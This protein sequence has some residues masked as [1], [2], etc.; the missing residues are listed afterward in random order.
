MWM[1]L[2]QNLTRMRAFAIYGVMLILV[3]IYINT[4]VDLVA[5]ARFW[6]DE[7]LAIVAA[8]Q[9]SFSAVWDAIWNGAEFSPPAYHFLLHLAPHLGGVGDFVLLRLPS[10]LALLFSALCIY[11]LLQSRLSKPLALLGFGVALNSGL[12]VFA[13]QARQYALVALCLSLALLLWDDRDRG[14]ISRPRAFLLWLT[15]VA[16]ICLHVY[17]LMAGVVIGLCEAMWF[18]R[19]RRIR[20]AIW[21]ALLGTLP[22]V[23]LL[24]R[25]LL[26]LASFN[27]HD[28]SSGA[29]YAKPT[30]ERF[31]DAVV[32]LLIGN[33][34]IKLIV[35]AA[36]IGVACGA[37]FFARIETGLGQ[38]LERVWPQEP[39]QASP[40][41][42]NIILLAMLLMPLVAQAFS[43]VVTG[44]FSPRYISAFA[45]FPALAIPAAIARLRF[46]RLLALALIPV[47]IGAFWLQN[48]RGVGAEK[49][50]F[51]LDMLRGVET[52]KPI[53]IAEGL[54]YIELAVAADP[55]LKA[56]LHF[57][58]HAPAAEGD[59]T[60]E[61][62]ALR[63][64]SID[65]AFRV[66]AFDAFVSQNPEF[67]VFYRPQE[68]A[69]LVTPELAKRCMIKTLAQLRGGVMLLEA[70]APM[71]PD[72]RCKPAL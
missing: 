29:Y 64:A 37:V 3:A 22:V 47:V 1:I 66:E 71:A 36:L 17:G 60:N 24:A 4:C 19:G 55:A 31:N 58:K 49:I 52:T 46:G 9:E 16:A 15:L 42:L 72:G 70:G 33:G 10:I 38:R 56:R 28:Q 62:Q 5:T 68:T 67:Y 14:N 18:I 69:D 34:G 53:V 44:A 8:R 30:F 35:F 43:V 2:E 57:L 7:A 25:L 20:L 32:D 11:G 41:N 51:A 12:F 40:D 21:G 23:A 65:G 26:H 61:N 13:L 50:T 39:P 6:M 45:L 63:L 48:R 59:T 27:S 54:L